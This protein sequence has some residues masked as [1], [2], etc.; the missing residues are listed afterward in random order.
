MMR[1][2]MD[3]RSK[4]F[5]LIEMLIVIVVIAILAL[6]VIPR[7]LGAGR[8]AKEA[9]LRGDLHQVR[10]AIQQFEADCGDYPSAISTLMTAAGRDPTCGRP[11]ATCRRTRSPTAARPGVTRQRQATCRVD[12]PSRRSTARPT[13]AGKRNEHRSCDLLT[14]SGIAEVNAL[15]GDFCYPRVNWGAICEHGEGFGGSV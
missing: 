7:L 2:M 15:R 13:A 6:I 10:N 11:T 5:T 9:T 4:G 3:R 1:R 12:R 8:K 14:R